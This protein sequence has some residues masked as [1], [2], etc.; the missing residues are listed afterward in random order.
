[1]CET[2]QAETERQARISESREDDKLFEPVAKRVTK[3]DTTWLESDLDIALKALAAIMKLPYC[4]RNESGQ[5]AREALER[6][7]N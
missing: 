7:N 2:Y 5:I 3:P 1:M 6:L 4:D